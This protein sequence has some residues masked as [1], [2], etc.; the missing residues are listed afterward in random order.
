MNSL[1]SGDLNQV[2]VERIGKPSIEKVLA[3]KIC[4]ALAIKGVFEVLK[5]QGI[6]EDSNIV[7]SS[8]SSTEWMGSSTGCK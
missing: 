2:L 4:Q 7:I 1:I 3:G 5:G 6:V 8:T